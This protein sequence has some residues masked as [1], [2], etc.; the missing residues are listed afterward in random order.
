[1][2]RNYEKENVDLQS[3]VTQLKNELEKQKINRE[4]SIPG[5]V[6]Q[7]Q[8]L[9]ETVKTIKS[10]LKNIH[11]DKTNEKEEFETKV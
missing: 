2:I 8:Q 1:M 5:Q 9:K 11:T 4:N 6:E 7:L 10:Q 3:Q